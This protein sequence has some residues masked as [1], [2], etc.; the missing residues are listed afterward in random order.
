MITYRRFEKNLSH[1]WWKGFMA[2]WSMSGLVST[3][4]GG[5]SLIFFLL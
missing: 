3:T 2:R 4:D 5:A 1:F